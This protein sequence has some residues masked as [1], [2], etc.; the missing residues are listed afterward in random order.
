MADTYQR[1]LSLHRGGE[2]E[3][4]RAL[5]RHLLR[6]HPGDPD[7]LH[8]LGVIAVQTGDPQGGIELIRQSLEIKPDQPEAFSSL[9]NALRILQK[10]RDALE[11]FDHALELDPR[12]APALNNR[13]SALLDLGRQDEALECYARALE[14]RPNHTGTLLN[15]GNTL[16]RLGRR[17]EALQSY[18]RAVQLRPDFEPALRAQGRTLLGLRR[19]EEAL[20]SLDRYLLLY[21]ERAEAHAGRGVALFELQRVE[22]AIESY[23]RAIALNPALAVAH[24]HR[25][26]ALSVQASYAEAIA[27]YGRVLE[28][29]PE[30]AWALGGQAHLKLMQCDWQAWPQESAQ[31]LSAVAEDKPAIIP[32]ALCAFTDSAPLQLRCAR[33]Y[34]ERCF[35]P[36]PRPVWAGESRAHDRIRVAYLSADFRTHPVTYTLTGVLERHDR[37]HFDITAISLRPPEDTPVGKRMQAAADRFVDV[38]MQSDTAVANL[39][40]ELEIDILVDLQGYTLG[41]RAGILAQRAAPI[42]VNFLGYPATMGA[43]YVDYILAD[44][45]VIPVGAE[46]DYA[47]QVVRLPH[48]Y[49]PFDDRQPISERIPT[50]SEAGLPETGF[51]FCAFNNTYKITPGVFDVWMSLLRRTPGSVLWLRSAGPVAT[52]NLQREAAG[53][54]VAPE[55]LIFAEGIPLLAEHLARLRL[56]DLFLDTLPYNAHATAAHALWAGVP[57]LS[58][59]GAAFAARVGASL[60]RAVG[61]SE[62]IAE[63]LQQYESLAVQLAASPEKLTAIRARLALNRRTCPLFDTSRSCRALESAYRTMW[64]RAQASEPPHSFSVAPPQ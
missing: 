27:S 29:E 33:T 13:G 28:L 59:R 45:V 56:A 12:C 48:C 43:P 32:L 21:P 36:A 53:R 4:A 10:P 37:R 63:D 60:L 11:S 20:A 8:Q 1:A 5:Y 51:V 57:V 26:V 55:R 58:C 6:T 40:R 15:H 3:Q 7:A 52:A 42:Q 46:S 44:D 31:L 50:R 47:E 14:L 61:L 17:A 64:E 39:I 9:G 24:F 34:V 38:L 35:P 41:T 23:D 16:V 25:A 30:C 54:G 62:L 19:L 22:E 49:L 2:F 18:E